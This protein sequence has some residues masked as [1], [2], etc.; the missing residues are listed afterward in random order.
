MAKDWFK[1]KAELLSYPDPEGMHPIEAD[2]RKFGRSC[3]HRMD[4]LCQ[5]HKRIAKENMELRIA[6]REFCERVERGEVRSVR[7]YNKFKQL[8]EDKQ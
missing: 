7:T 6:L 3:L 4:L 1:Q 8:L 5:D 2:W